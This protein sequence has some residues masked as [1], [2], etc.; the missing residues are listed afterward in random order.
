[1]THNEPGDCTIS[2]RYDPGDRT[3]KLYIDH[4]DPVVWVSRELIDDW[5]RA[6]HPYV[7]ITDD[8]F[9]IRASN[10]T[11]IYRIGEYDPQRQR[12]LCHWPD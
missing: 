11:V 12:Y 1:M 2:V 5:R 10:R 9:T 6:N 4:A 3:D 8:Q 7:E